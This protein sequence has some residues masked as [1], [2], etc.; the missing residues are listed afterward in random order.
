VL[1]TGRRY[2]TTQPILEQLELT[3]PVVVQ[4]GVVVKDGA[5]G[6]T[7]RASY[8]PADA[9][10]KALRL[11]RAVGP[12][13]VYV[14]EGPGS[15]VDLVSERGDDHHPF[16]AEYLEA[17]HAQIRWVDSL[18][19]PP[20]GA[21][22]MLSA[23]AKHEELQRIERTLAR[24]PIAELRANLIANKSYRG[25]ILEIVSNNTGKW[26]RLREIAQ[27]EAIS[28]DQIMAIGDDTN[29]REMIENAGLGVAMGNADPSVKNAADHVTESNDEDGATRAIQEHL[30]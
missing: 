9:Y 20:S 21:V 8:V 17:N 6:S 3:G 2:R 16:L 13:V 15:K 28:D 1:C 19:S 30:L 29:D 10:S 26:Q 5:T 7:L 25:H 18:A 11:L 22:A 4:N 12:P 14:D 23:M 24:S 27:T